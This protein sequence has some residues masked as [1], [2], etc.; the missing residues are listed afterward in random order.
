MPPAHYAE[1]TARAFA[2]LAQRHDLDNRAAMGRRTRANPVWLDADYADGAER[3]VALH[4]AVTAWVQG[5]VPP[6]L[7]GLR[8]IELN[9]AAIMDG[10]DVQALNDWD[11]TIASR[12]PHTHCLEA[13]EDDPELEATL[14]QHHQ[15]RED[16]LRGNLAYQRLVAVL[17][18]LRDGH[19]AGSPVVLYVDH[20]HRLLGGERASYPFDLRTVLTPLLSR[21]QIQLWGACTL[22]EYQSNVERDVSMER[23]FEVIMLPRSRTS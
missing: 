1:E 22:A 18:A 3:T 11:A 2:I 23:C 6:S 4:E 20:I 21:C 15:E 17:H 8:L 5:N 14:Q 9:Y 16:W 7:D 12:Y 10:I 13:L 19:D